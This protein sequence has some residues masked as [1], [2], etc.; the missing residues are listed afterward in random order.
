MSAGD[1]AGGAP[2]LN[3]TSGEVVDVPIRGGV[4]HTAVVVSD[5]PGLARRYQVALGWR[6]LLSVELQGDD[7]E[8]AGRLCGVAGVGSARVIMLESPDGA[9]GRV[10]FVELR[11]GA[12]E[13]ALENVTVLSFRVDDA[14]RSWQ[15][16]V[17]AG[18]GVV[19]P[20]SN[21]VVGGWPVT[22]ASVR[23]TATQLI[24]IM[25]LR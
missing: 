19:L 9:P 7:A 20:P 16:L 12:G 15:S 17:A 11:D 1:F 22:V 2:H 4:H 24:E 14:V 10:E 5:A 25:Q 6:Q 18:F 3:E 13:I 8:R 21:A 23:A